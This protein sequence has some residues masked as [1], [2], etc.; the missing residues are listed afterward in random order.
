ML[1]F[2][3]VILIGAG[4]M[5]ALNMGELSNSISS[6]K[7][8]LQADARLAL[9]W[10][11]KDARQAVVYQVANNNPSSTYIKLQ[12]VQ[13]WDTG[14]EAWVM[15]ADLIEYEYDASQQKIVRRLIDGTNGQT[16]QSWE[17]YNVVDVPFY[18]MDLNNNTVPLNKD[19]FN[20]CGKLIIMITKQ[21]QV[22]ELGGNRDISIT[23]REL[24][25]VRN[26]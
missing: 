22:H 13:G 6:A 14:A 19:D 2:F 23:L 11:V 9:E 18:T 7:A 1:V 12:Q 8:D 26:G 21:K 16:L 20:T 17:F 15:S 10:I 24:V 5:L 25:K 3:M 4:L